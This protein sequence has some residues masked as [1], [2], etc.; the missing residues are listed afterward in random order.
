V[1]IQK[2][3]ND[4]GDIYPPRVTLISPTD[5]DKSLSSIGDFRL[6]TTTTPFRVAMP[7]AAL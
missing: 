5:E 4:N 3:C 7:L 6:A 1:D 2:P